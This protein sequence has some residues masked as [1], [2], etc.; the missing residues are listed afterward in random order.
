VTF[1][2]VSQDPKRLIRLYSLLLFIFGGVGLIYSDNNNERLLFLAA[3]IAASG[4]LTLRKWGLIIAEIVVIIST[5]V[6][7]Y[8]I[9]FDPMTGG[10]Y[11]LLNAEREGISWIVVWGYLI[12]T[13]IYFILFVFPALHLWKK[14]D[15]FS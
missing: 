14:R 4:L 9:W 1:N 15:S 8:M 12:Y 3:I 6:Y 11:A 5:V 2:T 10:Y 7:M 13:F